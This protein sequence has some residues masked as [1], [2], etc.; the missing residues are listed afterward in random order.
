MRNN[1][2]V[3]ANWGML[4]SD[5]ARDIHVYN[6]TVVGAQMECIRLLAGSGEGETGDVGSYHPV[7]V[8]N[9]VVNCG[10]GISTD[11]AVNPVVSHNLFFNAGM[12][13]TNA[14]NADPLFVNEAQGDYRLQPDSPA[15][16][17]GTEVNAPR[18]AID[19]VLRP[20]GAGFD[21][22]AFER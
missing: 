1:L 18:D 13:G 7:A 17:S 6:N 3:N 10:T 11:G 21:R 14:L 15:V 8:N 20:Q 9:I 19:G 12:A 4:F 5:G 2:I 16:N 22:G